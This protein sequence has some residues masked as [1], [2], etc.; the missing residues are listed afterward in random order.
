[1]NTI[2]K[3][4]FVLITFSTLSTAQNKVVIEDL[5]FLNNTNW[6]GQ[7]TYLDYSSGKQST[8]LQT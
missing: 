8:I 1:M 4:L 2:I 6:V 3:T 5:H 7:L